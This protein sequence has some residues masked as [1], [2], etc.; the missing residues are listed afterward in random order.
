MSFNV[1]ATAAVIPSVAVSFSSGRFLA[2]GIVWVYMLAYGVFALVYGPL[3]RRVSLR[4]IKLVCF[5]LFS[6]G[7]LAAGCAPT[8]GLLL[9][10]RLLMGAFGASVIPL[11]LIV[12]GTHAPEDQRGRLVGS[13]FGVTFA[14][15]L[16]GLILSGVLHWRVLYLI[17]A[18]AGVVVWLLLLRYLPAFTQPRAQSQVSYA[19]A[20][21]DRRVVVL[22]GYIFCVSF[23]YHGVQGWLSVYYADARGFG[24]TLI[25]MLITFTS[26]SGI[27]GEFIGGTASDRWGRRK[28][29]SAGLLLMTGAVFLLTGKFPPAVYAAVMVIWGLGW[30][31]NHAGLSTML[32][33]LP[34]EFLNEAASLNSSVRFIAGGIGLALAGELMK[35][36][37]TL[38][39]LSFGACLGVLFAVSQSA[40][41]RRKLGI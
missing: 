5:A 34:S 19:S 3:A 32:T 27:F 8:L 28:T 2:G 39:F 30:T 38:G 6:L 33:D 11:A 29:V 15:S 13:F 31:F 37:F 1:A 41:I 17:P 24:Q 9:I 26:L 20:L 14:A 16:A 36:G 12:I 4:R 25:S 35:R 10:A 23:L 21:G 22:F 18:G 40:G 7:N